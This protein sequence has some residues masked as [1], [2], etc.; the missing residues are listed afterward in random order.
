MIPV[1]TQTQPRSHR[2]RC[3]RRWRCVPRTAQ[4]GR[5]L[6]SRPSR[7]P[8][9]PARPPSPAG[10]ACPSGWGWGAHCH[11]TPLQGRPLLNAPPRGHLSPT[12]DGW[13][14]PALRPDSA[15]ALHTRPAAVSSSPGWAHALGGQAGA[16]P[17]HA[18]DP[19][20]Q[21]NTSHTLHTSYI[22]A[23]ATGAS[24]SGEHRSSELEAPGSPSAQRSWTC[25][26]AAP[27]ALRLL[28]ETSL[29][30]Q[31]R[32]SGAALPAERPRPAGTNGTAGF[33]AT[34]LLPTCPKEDRKGPLGGA[35]SCDHSTAQLSHVPLLQ[36]QLRV[37]NH[38]D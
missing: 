12:K 17:L 23:S 30:L 1:G 15:S 37:K 10:T 34:G 11:C 16:R 2:A 3:V 9:P 35:E 22:S 36:G 19:S 4:T 25:S 14:S 13:A 29:L 5:L 24:F 6:G 21:S 8:A 20:A 32:T 38:F 27:E 7:R 18:C 33:P 31:R 28:H 26:A